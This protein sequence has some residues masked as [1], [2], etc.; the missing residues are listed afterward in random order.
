MGKTRLKFGI[1]CNG[2]T[3]ITIMTPE[4]VQPKE[5]PK[6]H[7]QI[8]MLSFQPPT[9]FYSCFCFCIQQVDPSQ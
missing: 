9:Y 1:P 5:T 2:G 3:E 8:E 6:Q 4:T 7:L